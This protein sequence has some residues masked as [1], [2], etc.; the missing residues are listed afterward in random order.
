VQR[1]GDE[2]Q[3]DGRA[4]LGLGAVR[5]EQEVAGV[6]GLGA[7]RLQELRRQ[8]TRRAVAGEHHQRTLGDVLGRGER[9]GKP[10]ED[11]LR[12]LPP[13]VGQV[14]GVLLAQALAVGHRRQHAGARLRPLDQ[15]REHWLRVRQV[16]ESLEADHDVERVVRHAAQVGGGILGFEADAL[17]GDPRHLD[18]GD[19]VVHAGHLLGVAG[20]DR[21]AVAASAARAGCTPDG[22]RQALRGA[23]VG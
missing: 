13:E 2:V 23:A 10:G 11:R 12:L 1:R 7:L 16:L 6:L 22:I 17:H 5:E 9:G 8:A 21:A 15:I 4:Q 18:R 20:E 19:V 3:A 14:V